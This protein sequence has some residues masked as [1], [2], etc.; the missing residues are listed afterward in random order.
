MQALKIGPFILMLFCMPVNA[1]DPIPNHT[2]AASQTS[3]GGVTPADKPT[4]KLSV[5]ALEAEKQLRATLDADSEAI[6]M[7]NSILQ[8]GRLGPADGWFPLAK[9]QSRF[10]WQYVASKYDQDQNGSIARD[11][12]SGSQLDFDRLD[13]NRDRRITEADFDWTQHSLAP[14]PGATLF[15]MADRDANGKVTREEFEKLFDLLGGQSEFVSL[16][17]LRDQLTPP[18]AA[19]N[20]PRP[21][22]PSRSTLV[23]GLQSQEVGSL[24]A[25]PNLDESAPDFTLNSLE[26]EALKL[27]DQIGEE[28]IVLIFGNFTCGPFRSQAGNLEKLYELYQDRANFYLIYVREAHPSDGW[29]MLSNERAGIKLPQPQDAQSRRAVAATCQSHLD[30]KIPFLVDTM[31]DAVGSAYSGMPN[32]LYLIDKQGKIAFKN[33]RGP[34]GFHV[35]QLEQALVL[36][37]NQDAPAVD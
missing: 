36:L 10:D 3:G 22:A 28:P 14:A 8:G 27:S 31:D 25:G 13:K 6:A 1:D 9:A 30:L 11:E 37:L 33:G 23:L 35:R 18:A 7:L 26:G 12:F 20:Q 4:D 5:E 24:Q 2:A 16:D 34:F 19:P 32:R 15:F 21:D 17:E 29:W